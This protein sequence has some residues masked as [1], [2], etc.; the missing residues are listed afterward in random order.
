[1][2]IV[3]N[4]SKLT[5][6]PLKYIDKIFQLEQDYICYNI[7][8]SFCNKQNNVDIDIGIGTLSIMVEEDNIL[9]KFIPSISLENDVKKTILT[10][11]APIIK[12]LES[13]IK[14]KV[15]NAYKDLI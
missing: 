1:M 5:G 12:K 11:E 9:Y 14:E 13:N 4:I 3:D 6:I 8:Q 15:L 7:Q 10:N 2:N